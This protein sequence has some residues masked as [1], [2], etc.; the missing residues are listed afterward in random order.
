MGGLTLAERVAQGATADTATSTTTSTS[1][2]TTTRS[3]PYYEQRTAKLAAA[4]QANRQSRWGILEESRAVEYASTPP[5]VGGA[6]AVVSAEVEAANHGLR[7]DGGVG[8]PSLAER[9]NLGALL[10]KGL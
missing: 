1:M 5:R 8:G 7:A 10:L 9:V 4:V 3:N 2:T 6:A